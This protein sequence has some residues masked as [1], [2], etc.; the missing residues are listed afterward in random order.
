MKRTRQFGGKKRVFLSD[1]MLNQI[2][3][4]NRDR[5]SEDQREVIDLMREG[6]NTLSDMQKRVVMLMVDQNM[7][8]RK[9]AKVLGIEYPTLLNHLNRARKKLKEYV[10][11]N[12][13]AGIYSAGLQ[14]ENKPDEATKSNE[15]SLDR[16]HES[17]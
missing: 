6:F 10:M 15:S 1:E 8:E 11:Q 3:E 2:P 7:S 13:N 4:Q 9:A 17:N 16:D 12:L 5:L 14:E